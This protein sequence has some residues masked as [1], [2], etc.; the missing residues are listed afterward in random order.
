VS[1]SVIAEED[2]AGTPSGF[3]RITGK[4]SIDE[5]LKR[6]RSWRKGAPPRT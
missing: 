5:T 2:D 4:V 3:M 6:L 1:G